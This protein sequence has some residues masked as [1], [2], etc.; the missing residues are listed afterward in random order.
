MPRLTFYPIGN[1]DSC[2]IDLAGGQKIL[3]DYADQKNRSDANDLRIDLEQA[4]R[5]DLAK[6]ERKDVDVFCIT[7]LDNDHI[8]G[9]SEL[10]WLD[11]AEKYQGDDRIKIGELWVP[12]AVLVEEGCED[13]SRI[14]RQ[15]AR[16]RFKAQKGIRVFSGPEL[17]KKWVKDQGLD[18]DDYKHLIVDAGTLVPTFSL[19]GHGAEFFAHSPFAKRVDDGGLVERNRDSIVMHVTFE[20][21]GV[22]TRLLLTADIDH[23]VIAD[24]VYMTKKRK[25]E[26]RLQWDV[27]ELPHHCS[28]KSIGPEKGATQTAPVPE[29][30]ELYETYGQK[31]GILVSTS[32]PIPMGYDD[33]QPPHRQ[34]ANYYRHVLRYDGGLQGRFEVTMEHPKKSAPKPLVIEIDS[35]K[36]RLV[37][38]VAAGSGGLTG[39][40]APRAG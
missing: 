23:E 8:C 16:H 28:Y 32:W 17:M 6:A 29:V 2:L 9:S 26:E 22:K 3:V 34:A 4:I 5:D 14:W 18:W 1:A 20:V 39:G 36:A 40:S 37:T 35:T 11:H 38:V 25:R 12:A 31:R 15:E 27:L 13:E 21:N 7:H 10:F 33:I 24:I 30:K 19:A